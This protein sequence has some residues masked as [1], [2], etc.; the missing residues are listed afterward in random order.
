MIGRSNGKPGTH[1]VPGY[2]RARTHVKPAQKAVIE[3]TLGSYLYLECGHLTTRETALLFSVFAPIA[4]DVY[5]EHCDKFTRVRK[6]K[7]N[8]LYPHNP[9]F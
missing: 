3:K 7:E 9:L 6:P 8:N 4:K 5:C 2:S 1:S